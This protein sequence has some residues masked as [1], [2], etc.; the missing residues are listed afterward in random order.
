MKH[1]LWLLQ[2]FPLNVAAIVLGLRYEDI[3]K[4]CIFFGMQ[5]MIGQMIAMRIGILWTE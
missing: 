5:V 4:V 1:S 2:E 3:L